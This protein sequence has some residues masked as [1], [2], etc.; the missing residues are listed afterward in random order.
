MGVA[1]VGPNDPSSAVRSPLG[2]DGA[3]EV[4]YRG[5]SKRAG[6]GSHSADVAHDAR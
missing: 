6:G 5:A 2:R 3:C 1:R 4:G